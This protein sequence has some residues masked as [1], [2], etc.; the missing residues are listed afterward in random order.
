MTPK[1][2]PHATL[3]DLLDRV[4]DKG[5]V[6]QAD[7]IV[8]VA[9]IP[10]IGVNLRAALAGMETMLK[11]GVM[12]KWDE[13]TRAWEG[14]N[15]ERKKDA[16]LAGEELRLKM[17]GGCHFSEGLYKA[18][19]Y[20]RFYVTSGRLL[21]YHETFSRVLFEAPLQEIRGLALGETKPSSFEEQ[22][23]E[24]HLLLSGNRWYRLTAHSIEELKKGLE[25]AISDIGHSLQAPPPAEERET[26]PQ[27]GRLDSVQILLQNGCAQCGWLSPFAARKRP[28]ITVP[29]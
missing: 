15:R 28:E 19:Q 3:V 7:L 29:V 4:L 6:I 22:R 2:E 13:K 1:R 9:G 21:L 8:S 25:V 10:L 5:L 23:R 26:C 12:T 16:L 20:G 14:E 18:W 11:Y 27:C 17:Q 24:L